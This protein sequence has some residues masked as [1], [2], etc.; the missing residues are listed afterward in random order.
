MLGIGVDIVKIARVERVFEKFGPKFTC[1]ILSSREMGQYSVDARFL[2]KRFAAKE[3]IAKALGTGF[4]NGVTMPCISIEKNSL[5]Q[6]QVILDGA[7][8]ARLISMGG[9]DV[10]L[11]LSDE[12]DTVV[13]FAVV[14]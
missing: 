13:A 10:L 8:Q 12:V 2:A 7:A 9:R 14:R 4:R 1:K 6:P 5:N 3:A 11:S